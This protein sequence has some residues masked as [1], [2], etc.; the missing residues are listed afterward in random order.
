MR[1]LKTVRSETLACVKRDASAGV[2]SWR[3]TAAMDADT[4]GRCRR[5]DGSILTREGV[6]NLVGRHVCE[7]KAD[8]C[9]C[10]TDIEEIGGLAQVSA[11]RSS[12]RRRRRGRSTGA[13]LL[14]LPFKILGWL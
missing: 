6:E 3:W 4:C 12:G 2:T 1:S 7:N 10:G 14:L 9:R 11:P 13:R 8:G 5:L